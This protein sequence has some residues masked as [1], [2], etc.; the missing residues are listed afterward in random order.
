MT[1]IVRVCTIRRNLINSKQ[2]P[3][4]GSLH[5]KQLLHGTWRDPKLQ[6]AKL[7]ACRKTLVFFSK[8]SI[9]SPHQGQPSTLFATANP[10][11][12]APTPTASAQCAIVLKLQWASTDRGLCS[13]GMRPFSWQLSRS[14]PPRVG[15]IGVHQ[16]WGSVQRKGSARKLSPSFS[17]PPSCLRASSTMGV[18]VMAITASVTSGPTLDAKTAPPQS[19]LDMVRTWTFN[20]DSNHI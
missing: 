3:A 10:T 4:G 16:D 20:Q 2:G 19:E 11:Q 15:F 14:T 1:L 5:K 9:A 18:S 13:Q 7:L 8:D 6:S 17:P 12:P